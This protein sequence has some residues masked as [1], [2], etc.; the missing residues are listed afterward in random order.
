MEVK[1]NMSVLDLIEEMGKS[2]VLGAG[3]VS[4]AT[5]LFADSIKDEDTSVF[6]SVAGPLV[7]GGLRKIIFD[8]IN[9]GFVDVLITSGANITHDLVESF[10][11]GHYRGISADD[12]ELCQQ[13]MGRIG[14]VYTKSHDF[15]VFEEKISEILSKIAEKKKIISI[16]EFLF[17]IGNMIE[18]ENSILK[19]AA[20]KGVP[21][22]APGII[23]S[24][25]GLQLWMFTQ[26]K[27]LHLDAVGDMSELS[28]IVFDAKKVTA[29]LLGGGL[30]KH[31][32]LASNLLKGGVDAAIQV[33]M[34]RSET[35]SLSGAPL[36]EAKSWAKAK[37]G[38][39]LVTVIGD[40]TIIFP[41][42]VAGAR[43][44]IAR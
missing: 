4:K 18:D 20:Q 43:E 6:L 17:E 40:V 23:D 9:D 33:T 38:S 8:L 14:D 41:M 36:E 28:D 13:G 44:I 39:N 22:Y 11:G 1:E 30:P 37:A 35:G 32:A 21:I 42:M 29:V 10:G 5:H 27:E 12:E 2:G 31:Y 26:D 7:P 19:I 16:R 15:E 34:D 3:R 25:L 24:M